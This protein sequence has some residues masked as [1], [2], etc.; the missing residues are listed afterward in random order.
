VSEGPRGAQGGNL[1]FLSGGGFTQRFNFPFAAP[2]G[3]KIQ[4]LSGGQLVILGDREDLTGPDPEA[5]T[6]TKVSIASSY[7]ASLVTTPRPPA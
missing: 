5:T 1:S 3:L 6:S 2:D 4:T 7:S